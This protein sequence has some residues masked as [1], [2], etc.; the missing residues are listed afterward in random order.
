MGKKILIALLLIP[1]IVNAKDCDSKQHQEYVELSP[2][3]TYDNDYS[4]SAGSFSITIY[5]IF[6]DMYA[7]IGKKTYKPDSENKVLISSVKEG[8]VLDIDIYAD[9][10]CGSIKRITVFEPYYNPYYGEDICA[11][12]EDK[13]PV[14]SSQFTEIEVTSS[15]VRE[16]IKNYDNRGY[17]YQKE[18]PKEKTTIEKIIDFAKTWGIKI[19]L[20]AITIFISATIYNIKFRKIK[21]GI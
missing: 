8:E 9:D 14:C 12:Y 5:N 15:L 20:V 3:I 11:G 2:R 13:V 7:K 19:V 4:K 6:D 18:E 21:H 1:M 10:G 17:Q 16:S